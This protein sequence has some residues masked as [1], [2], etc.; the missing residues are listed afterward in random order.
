MKDHDLL[1][2]LAK[3]YHPR[4]E[5]KYNQNTLSILERANIEPQLDRSVPRTDL[6]PQMSSQSARTRSTKRVSDAFTA[7]VYVICLTDN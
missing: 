6:L 5:Q 7:L 4:K 3:V 2:K 1:S